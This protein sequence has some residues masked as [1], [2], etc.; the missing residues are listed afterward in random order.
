MLVEFV[1][2]I[3]IMNEKLINKVV[4]CGKMWYIFQYI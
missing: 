3:T 2:E 4:E 1:D